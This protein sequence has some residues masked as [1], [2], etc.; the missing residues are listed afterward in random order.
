[1]GVYNICNQGPVAPTGRKMYVGRKRV[2][3]W[4]CWKSQF[5]QQVAKVT[6]SYI[7]RTFTPAE[8]EAQ[9]GTSGR[10][11][12]FCSHLGVRLIFRRSFNSMVRSSEN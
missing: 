7:G 3:N 8:E 6:W 2:V 4:K 10:I 9:S 11:S 5:H 12:Y 1:M